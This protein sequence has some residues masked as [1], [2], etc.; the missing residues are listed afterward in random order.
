MY[1]IHIVAA[2]PIVEELRCTDYPDY[3]L[4]SMKVLIR[5]FP[6]AMFIKDQ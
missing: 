2:Q 6:K 5:D 3:Y 1:P 4:D